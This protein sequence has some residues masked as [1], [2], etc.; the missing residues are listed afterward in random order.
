[1]RE[2]VF[3]I[4]L[5]DSHDDDFPMN[6]LQHAQVLHVLRLESRG[7]TLICRVAPKD[8]APFQESLRHINRKQVQVVRLNRERSGADLFQVLGHF[9]RDPRDPE[10]SRAWRFFESIEKAPIYGLGNPRIEGKTLKVSVLADENNIK[11]LLTGMREVK[12]PYKIVRLGKLKEDAQTPIGA[13][14]W[15]QQRVIRL[16][17]TLGYYDIPRRASTEDLAKV[18]KM[19]KGTVGEHLRRAEKNVFDTLL[20]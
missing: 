1:L 3:D 10:L 16:A 11:R 12:V 7:F 5:G 14:T 13:L 20:S 4:P 9:K 8:S 17:H 19:D 2:L 6:L 18:L 15:Q